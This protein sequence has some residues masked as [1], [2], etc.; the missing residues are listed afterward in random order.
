MKTFTRPGFKVRLRPIR[1]DDIDHIMAW[2]ND[3]EVTKNFANMSERITREQEIAWLE[4]VMASDNDR[5]Y[6]VE[7]LEGRYLGNAGI[8]KI[9]WPARNGRL[10]LVLGA[11]DA[12]GRG[13]G[14]QAMKLLVALAFE[15]LGLHKTWLVHYKTNERMAHIA[16]K[17]GFTTEGVLRDEYF[18]AQSFHDMVRWSLLEDELSW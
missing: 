16:T 1:A 9:Y 15:E 13:L 5:L 14:T 11:A 4:W 7:D 3:P 18:H 8:H 12:R 17:L 10:G 2:I 6:A